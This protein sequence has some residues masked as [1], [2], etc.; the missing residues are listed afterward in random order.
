[1]ANLTWAGRAAKSGRVG[2]A[3]STW[4]E[5]SARQNWWREA[6]RGLVVSRE[7]VKNKTSSGGFASEIALIR[8]QHLLVVGARTAASLRR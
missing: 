1:V 3:D 7:F 5:G 4:Q 6:L 2:R 8:T